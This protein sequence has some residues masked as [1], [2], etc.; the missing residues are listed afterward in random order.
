M[1]GPE[2]RSFGKALKLPD[3]PGNQPPSSTYD[4]MWKPAGEAYR[5]IG[6]GW[7]LWPRE[8]EFIVGGNQPPSWVQ[9]RVNGTA[10]GAAAKRT[11]T[12]RTPQDRP[13]RI[14]LD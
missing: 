14:N 11:H 7:F 2:T 12:E 6:L 5:H 3:L 10:E 13:E 9:A 1:Q 4:E 8:G